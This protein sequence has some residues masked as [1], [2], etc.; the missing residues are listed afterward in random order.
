MG[1]SVYNG[2]SCGSGAATRLRS[3]AF[4]SFLNISRFA[5]LLSNSSHKGLVTGIWAVSSAMVLAATFCFLDMPYSFLSKLQVLSFMFV[6]NFR[7]CPLPL[8]LMSFVLN[9]SKSCTFCPLGQTQF[10]FFFVK[11]DHVQGT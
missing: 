9:V 6:P 2:S 10:F 1:L 8:K 5:S 7:R 4:S 11:T 3:G